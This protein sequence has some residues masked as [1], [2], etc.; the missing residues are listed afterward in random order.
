MPSKYKIIR[1]R[2]ELK[3]I[4]RFCKKT[5]YA[6]VDF[7]T[8][9]LPI[10]HPGFYPTILGV[11]FQIG[12]SYIIPLGHFDS[13][14]LRGWEKLLKRFGKE[15]I[16]NTDITKIAWNLSFEKQIFMKF[17]IK[18][19][20]RLMDAML[21]KYLLDEE[22]PNDLKSIVS[23]Y[24][25][26]YAGY[27]ESYEGSKLPWDR[28]PLEGLSKYCGLD[29][30]LTFRLMMFFEKQLIKNDFYPLFRNMLMMGTRVLSESEYAG[31]PIDVPY[32]DNLIEVYTEKIAKK[33]K[34]L[35]TKKVKKF[36]SWLVNK[37][38]KKL[39]I[40]VET[41]IEDLEEE[42]KQLVKEHKKTGEQSLV[43]K[44]N[45]KKRAIKGREE[46]IDR[47]VA[48]DLRTKP[49]LKCLEPFNFASPA[50]LVDLLFLS[51]KGY[52]YKVISYT[53]DK[54]TKKPTKTP[55]TDESVLIQ[56]RDKYNS[57]FCTKLLEYRGITKLFSTYI[58]GI[59]EKV[60]EGRVHG[61]YKLHGTVTG[62][63]SSF[64]P[65]LQNIPRDTTASD[66]KPMFVPPPGYVLLQLDYSQAE[67]RVMAAMAKEETMIKWFKEGK[68]I[69]LTVALK[70]D[71]CEDRYDE[72]LE[73]LR[74]E[75]EKDPRF[76]EWKIKRKYAKTINFGIIYGQGAPKLAEALGCSVD[77][78]KQFLKEYF[79]LFP[80]IARF[81]KNQHRLAHRKGYVRNVF[82]RKRRLWNIDSSEKYLVAEAERQSVNAPI[83]GAASD[84]TLFSSILIWEKTQ[85]GELEL[86]LPQAY[87]VH[88]SIGYWVRPK[89]LKTLIPKLRDICENPETKEWFNFEIEGVTMAVD[90][91]VSPY[92]WGTLKTYSPDV[93][94]VKLVKEVNP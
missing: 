21:A 85:T 70:K 94:Y 30:D 19:K 43:T 37:R 39:I 51:P 3:D 27:E 28:K 24:I 82:G 45:A 91:E 80:K 88:D 18:M 31:M 53:V 5:G 29:C 87:T 68:D 10:N 65:N 58:K 17:G 23:R 67:L 35:Y 46:K 69:H 74:L 33:E 11:S 36:E 63:L 71:N 22:R 73:V 57:D 61:R 32:L 38:I 62:R 72:I 77:E 7:E 49:E 40:S 54:K 2:H 64:D 52:K 56:L 20:G 81:I 84:Y 25:P 9:G 48:K 6:S 78:A 26:E 92:N 42:L 76:K 93:D 90:F 89:H 47:Y 59:R 41:E 34:E 8:N 12:S 15:V 79:K 66:I 4:I 14:F 1:K 60:I 55:S 50:Q 86:D 16:E 75:D 83:Q 13:P 44:I